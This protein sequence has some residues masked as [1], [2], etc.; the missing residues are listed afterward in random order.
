MDSPCDELP[1]SHEGVGVDRGGV[2]VVRGAWG[3]S[4]V[5]QEVLF[6]SYFEALV[7]GNDWGDRG[8][9]VNQVE[10]DWG[11]ASDV[12]NKGGSHVGQG[13]NGI[14]AVSWVPGFVQ[15]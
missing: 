4:A 2:G 8:E 9:V 11:Q 5:S 13:G 14:V 3:S 15:K 7:G 6:S 12:L 10:A 1:K